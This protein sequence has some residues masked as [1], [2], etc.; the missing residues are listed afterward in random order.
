MTR[1]GWLLFLALGAVWGIPY[2]LIRVAVHDLDP[3]VVAFGRCAIGAL[4]LLPIALRRGLLRE[5]LPHWRWV[6]VFTLVEIT[7]PWLLLGHAETVLTS[8]LAGLLVAATPMLAVVL[9][10]RLG[11]ERLDPRRVAGLAVGFVGL[12]VVLG[13]DLA[14]ENLWAVGAVFLVS[15]GYATGPVVI[16]RHLDG[17]PALGVV[18]VSLVLASA[19]YAPFVPASLP[20]GSVPLEAVASVV[21]L[22]TLCTAA[23]FV[24]FFALVAEAGPARSTVITY[25]NPVVALALGT[26]VLD[27]PLTAA[28]PLGLVLVVGG[29]ILATAKPREA[30]AIAPPVPPAPVVTAEVAA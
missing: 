4:V 10:S 15:L 28:L 22:G 6:V 19:L 5:V 8:S 26:L 14:A 23:A 7:G 2:L 12:V 16:A 25:L 13:L 1:R 21:A 29:S 20:T 9:L 18:T 30:V 24:V 27:E 3:V 17:V 11:M